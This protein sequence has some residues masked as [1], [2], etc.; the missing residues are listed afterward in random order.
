MSSIPVLFCARVQG[1]PSTTELYSA[2]DGLPPFYL[3]THSLATHQDLDARLEID[4][5]LEWLGGGDGGQGGHR[6]PTP[7][8]PSPRRSP[9]LQA[10]ALCKVE[11]E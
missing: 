6:P 2:L 7:Q 5:M 8:R 1:G 3:L 4:E 9:E 11:E 10:Q